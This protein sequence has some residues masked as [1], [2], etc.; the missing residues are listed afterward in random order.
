M[1]GPRDVVERLVRRDLLPVER[2][3]E[4][5]LEVRD[6]SRRN[7]NLRVVST[8]GPALFVKHAKDQPVRLAQEAWALRALAADPGLAA[9]VTTL[10]DHDAE[11]GLLVLDLV[12]GETL[13]SYHHRA[14]R[15]PAE[16]G[17]A[18]GTLLARVHQARPATGPVL[19]PDAP[20]VFLLVRP[21]LPVVQELSVANL[22][23]VRILQEFPDLARLLAEVRMAWQPSALIHGDLKWDNVLLDGGD[24]AKPRIADWES[25]NAGDPCWDVGCVFS[26]HL[27]AWLFSIPVRPDAP[28]ERNLHLA[29]LPLEPMLPAL[30]AFWDAYSGTM[31]F[32]GPERA[33]RLRRSV[34]LAGARLVQT[35][36]EHMQDAPALTGHAVCVLQL[37]HNVLARPDEA[38]RVLLRLGEASE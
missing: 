26:E 37:A 15:F 28:P 38:A 20:S 6:A 1:M 27:S 8:R 19:P 21:M 33:V 24:P 11:A 10:R 9:G 30:R 31:G 17:A 4:G 29:T 32:D 3:V 25:A 2:I 14:R 5:D 35:A 7:R 16:G 22:R 18:L 36:Y 12:E 13:Q 23:V 34:L